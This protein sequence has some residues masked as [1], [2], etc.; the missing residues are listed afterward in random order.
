MATASA[1]G[2]A[3]GEA[4]RAALDRLAPA[5]CPV[6]LRIEQV[7]ASWL[8]AALGLP[9]DAITDVRVLDANS[10]TAA[11]A[12]IAVESD[13]PEIPTHLFVK[14]PPRDYLQHVLMN[15]FR[16]GEREILAYRALGDAPPVR[17]PRCHVAQS[18]PRY[19]R[20]ALVLEDL[21]GTARFRTVTDSV[22]RAE[23]ES[24]IDAMADLHLAFQDSDRFTG[25][26]RPLAVRTAAD[27]RL[28]DLIRRRFLHEITGHTA[29]LIPEPIKLQCRIFYRRSADIDA[30]WA[31]QP[32]TLIHA[33][34]HLGNLYFT[35]DG[36]GFLDWQIATIG[37]GIRDLAYFATASIE[38]DLLRGIERDLVDRYAARFDAAG[39][40]VDPDRLWTLYRAA[41]TELFL[42]IVCTAEAGERMQPFEVSRVGVQRAVAAVTTHDSFGVL[43]TLIDGGDVR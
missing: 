17:V 39:V 16:L 1:V 26:L 3:A 11:R 6:P 28:G 36:P 31:A 14:L 23:A 15:V 2:M 33:D 30:F 42:A 7:S 22:T 32:Q 18:D 41:I 21:T 25:D 12:R 34:P 43:R 10:G 4:I 9:A 38:P 20:S 29:D 5:S 13:R 35:D 19:R 24:V 40:R 37:A 27:V 8:A